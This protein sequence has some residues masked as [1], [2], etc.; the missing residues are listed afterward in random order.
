MITTAVPLAAAIAVVAYAL[1]THAS[2]LS[3][4]LLALPLAAL[5]AVPRGWWTTRSGV[6]VIAL[7]IISGTTLPWLQGLGLERKYQAHA[8]WWG[9]LLHGWCGAGVLLMVAA[10][11]GRLGKM[12]SRRC[13]AVHF[14]GGVVSALAGVA[15]VLACAPLTMLY[16]PHI[17]AEDAAIVRAVSR[18]ED[19]AVAGADGIRLAARWYEPLGVAEPVG[20]VVFTHGFGGWKEGFKNHLKLFTA[21]GWA[22]MAYDL[23][24]HGRS[25]PAAVTFG[26]REQED[27]IAVWRAARDRARGKPMV[28]YGVSLGTS[29]VLLAGDRLEGA[30]GVILD[31]PFADL[32]DMAMVQL[33]KPLAIIAGA[34]AAGGV[35]LHAS[36]VRPVASPV[37][38]HGPPLLIGW[39]ADDRSIPAQQSEQVAR[40]SPRA[41]TLVMPHGDH[42][43]TATWLPWRRAVISFLGAIAP[44]PEYDGSP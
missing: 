10:L 39:I 34:W 25:S 38:A 1:A 15:G 16:V 41:I 28:A 5:A 11:A 43:D 24:G 29:V 31:S 2:P 40:A 44:G 13:A 36:D 20:V 30:R 21:S 33:P 12:V 3:A 27:L 23:R 17:T 19:L 8:V 42:L 14:L 26:K 18:S 7:A 4:T 32:A 37:L 9:V 35:G 6:L 22:V